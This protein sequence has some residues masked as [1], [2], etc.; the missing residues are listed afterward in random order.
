MTCFDDA[1]KPSALKAAWAKVVRGKLGK[2]SATRQGSDGHS[3]HSFNLRLDDEIAEISAKLKRGKYKFSPLDPYFVP[4]QDGKLRVI[5]A[6]TIADRVVQRSILDAV[7]SKQAWMNNPVSYGFV[8]EK[9]VELAA[10][11]AIEYRTAKPWVFKT[12][13]TKFFDCVDRSLLGAKIKQQV[14]Q[15]SL[16]PLILNAMKCEILT[17]HPSQAKRITKMGIHVGH[18]V[19]QGMPLSPFFA[20]LFLANFD[21][22]CVSK[23][24][25]V[26]RYAD[27]LIFF[28]N[29][30]AEAA[31][32]EEFCATELGKIGLMIPQLAENTKT[33]IYAPNKTAEFLGVELAPCKD[34]GYEVRLGQKQLDAI[35]STIYDMGSLSELRRQRL[36]I[37]RFG[38]SL[39]SRAASYSAT[40]DFCCNRNQLEACLRDWIKATKTRIAISLGIEL[41]TLSDDGRWFLG[42]D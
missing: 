27:D 10:I 18:G 23:N 38:N 2:P 33:Q 24:M 32:F 22:A 12:D 29:S 37:S 25:N 3:L 1:I 30:Q 42:L 19:R 41:E 26:L 6:P 39:N 35:K 28:G 4:K 7:S 31:Y 40:Y 17:K 21:K 11:K 8:S 34:N 13:I 16:H 20:N 15:T 14:K 9:G 5:C 36:D